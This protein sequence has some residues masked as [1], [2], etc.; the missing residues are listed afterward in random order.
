M[1]YR[2]G[3]FRR[4]QL[5]SYS[6][7]L[8]E[9]I[10]YEYDLAE[11]QK[12][13]D[14]DIPFFNRVCMLKNSN[15]SLKNPNCYYLRFKV[16]QRSDAKQTFYLKIRKVSKNEDQKYTYD[17]HLE[18]FIDEFSINQAEE[19]QEKFVYFETIIS[20]NAEYN[21][22]VWELQRDRIDYQI[23]GRIMNVYIEEF[24]KLDNILTKNMFNNIPYLSKIG[25]Q[26]PPSLLMCINREPIRLGKTG[27]YEI[28]NGIKI[29]SISF[30]P[31]NHSSS[32]NE[33]KLDYFIMDYEYQKEE[34]T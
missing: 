5:N 21:Q 19:G 8:E 28:N 24:S 12:I 11:T 31:K 7:L 22:I 13:N 25:I 9:N 20:P 27:I 26:G 3:Q 32:E 23:E 2:I 16:L 14:A 29:T 33:V 10:D 1:S 6:E 18:Q 34:E 30:V 15:K 4:P 17:I